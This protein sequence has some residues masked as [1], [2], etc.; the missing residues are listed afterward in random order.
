[1]SVKTRKKPPDKQKIDAHLTRYNN[2]ITSYTTVKTS[3][4]SVVKNDSVIKIINKHVVMV[5]KIVTHTYQFLKLYCIHTFDTTNQ[6]PTIDRLL[7]YSIM[8]ILCK[9]DP[10]GRKPDEET[11]NLKVVLKQFY[12]NH[13]KKLLYKEEIL[14]YTHLSNVLEYE[15]VNMVTVISNH[16]QNHFYTFFNRYINVTQKYDTKV[17]LIKSCNSFDKNIRTEFDL[18]P[19]KKLDQQLI[20][21]M[22]SN[23]RNQIR[24]LKVDLWNNENKCNVS[25]NNDKNRIK[26]KFPLLTGD[27]SI[28][29]ILNSNPTDLLK[30]MIMM[31]REIESIGKSTFGCFPLRKN[32]IP[33]YIKIDTATIIHML[34]PAKV[35][36]IPKNEYLT[37]GNI[38]K[39]RDEIW[40]VCFKTDKKVFN[41]F[42]NKRNEHNVTKHNYVFNNQICTDGVACSILQIRQD[43]Y[44]PDKFSKVYNVSKPNEYRS[45]IYVSDFSDEDKQKYKDYTIVGVDPGK[46]DLLYA[47]NGNTTVIKKKRPNPDKEKRIETP[48]VI[49]DKHK[50]DTF[51]YSQNQ[52]RK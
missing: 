39:L 32:I 8:K 29:D 35:N 25:Y 10:R 40:R 11:D 43:L 22:V 33:K 9:E 16:I 2:F 30:M 20:D 31:S 21:K 52:R 51:R 1:M 26:A 27:V 36:E 24:R 46:D 12:D 23:Y 37:N 14:T 28:N 5:N 17:E 50:T 47:T 34:F 49:T 13:Y 3:L 6:L 45:T 15:A 48:F 7:I 4:K 18:L 41:T 38:I 19:I 44:N 42:S